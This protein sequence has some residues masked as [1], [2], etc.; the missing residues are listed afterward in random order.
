M[1]IVGSSFRDD[2]DHGARCAAIFRA[3]PVRDDLKLVNGFL[4]NRRANA[5]H[6]V[7]GSVSAIHV[8]QVAAGALAAGV[9]P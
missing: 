6:R 1:K 2:V 7:V 4:R 5:V 9:D 8:H 3:V